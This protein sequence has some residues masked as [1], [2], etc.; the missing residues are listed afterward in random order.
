MPC[1]L[2]AAAFLSFFEGNALPA[3][4]DNLTDVIA[5]NSNGVNRTSHGAGR[6]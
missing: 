1:T 2:Q 3:E 4:L 6:L 5:I